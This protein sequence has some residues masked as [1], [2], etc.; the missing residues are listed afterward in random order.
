MS[1]LLTRKQGKP[2]NAPNEM[3][4][5]PHVLVTENREE[6]EKS[7][8]A[9]PSIHTGMLTTIP[10]IELLMVRHGTSSRGLGGESPAQ[11]D[12]VEHKPGFSPLSMLRVFRFAFLPPATP[13]ASQ[14]GH[15]TRAA[16]ARTKTPKCHGGSSRARERLD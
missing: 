5:W 13:N 11:L 15:V 12:S 1:A 16:G 7:M 3:M 14:P 9:T 6:I 10:P 4:S 2:E 8:T